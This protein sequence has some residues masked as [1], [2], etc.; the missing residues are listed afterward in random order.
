MLKICLRTL[1]CNLFSFVSCDWRYI[2]D[3]EPYSRIASA[4]WKC[5]NG[6]RFMVME[7]CLKN[8][9][10]IWPHVPLGHDIICFAEEL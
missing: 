5:T 4:I 1:R 10:D 7:G 2:C 6:L 8:H 9:T 3:S